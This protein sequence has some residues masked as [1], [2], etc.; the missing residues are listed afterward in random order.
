MSDD[1]KQVVAAT[2]KPASACEAG[3]DGL[4]TG[5]AFGAIVPIPTFIIAYNDFKI[6][7]LAKLKSL[8]RCST[9][10]GLAIGIYTAFESITSHRSDSK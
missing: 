6:N 3:L 8:A 2:K 9:V 1:I 4:C 7:R 5:V 10:T